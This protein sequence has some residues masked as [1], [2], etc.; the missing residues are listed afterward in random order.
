MKSGIVKSGGRHKMGV[1]VM[2]EG[3]D[4]RDDQEVNMGVL[5]MHRCQIS[6]GR[7]CCHRDR[8]PGG[9]AGWDPRAV[10]PA[11]SELS[12]DIQGEITRKVWQ[13]VERSGRR[14]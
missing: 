11:M 12:R 6:G 5:A 4:A 13:V 1:V 7:C 9:G 2:G 3:A 14:G 8:S 10:V